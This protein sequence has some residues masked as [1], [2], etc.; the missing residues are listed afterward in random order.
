MSVTTTRSRRRSIV[1]RL[2]T[3]AAATV[4]LVGLSGCVSRED[5]STAAANET[6]DVSELAGVTLDVG[7]QRGGTE[8]LLRAAGQLDDL[9]YEINFS[10]FT[11]GPPQIEAATA[12]QIDFAVTGN[13]PPIFGAAANARIKIVSAYANGAEG[14]KILAPQGSDITTV[15]ALRGKKVAVARGSSAHGHLLVQLKRAGLTLGEDV[16]P[17]FLQ[18]ADALSGFSTGSVDAWAIWDPYTAIVELE[19]EPI[20]VA[21]GAGVVNGY[22]FGIAGVDAL[23]DPKTNSAI[24]DL[25]VR[26]AKA[27][28]WAT[29]NLDEWS[30][31]Y[32]AAIEI[33]P[34]AATAAQ[35]RSVRPAI[36]L[37]DDV[38]ASEQELADA[39][40]ESR[41]LD[42]TPSIADFVDNR[43]HEALA[44]HY[45]SNGQ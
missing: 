37:S 4:L 41:Q 34:S 39:F 3:A 26:L 21:T 10:T 29:E 32:A 25:V 42:T 11:S 12:G 36:A 13:T 16:E 15:A 19:S 28:T 35:R 22:G 18:P 31:Q 6:V 30:Q 1:T 27:S 5:N 9:P 7:D 43:Y 8:S 38:V 33:D 23:E 24:A 20:T 44:P 40:G 45:G 17:V 2:I 14:D